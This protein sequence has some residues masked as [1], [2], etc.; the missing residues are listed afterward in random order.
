MSTDN[1]PAPQVEI[2]LPELPEPF[3]IVKDV[4]RFNYIHDVD[5]YTADQMRAYAQAAL[6]ARAGGDGWLPIE[7]AP[8]DGTYILA[9]VPGFVP[10]VAKWRAERGSFEYMDADNFSSDDQYE[11]FLMATDSW[12]PTHWQPLPTPPAALASQA[13]GVGDGN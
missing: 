9:I 2:Q 5:V 13:V 10:A 11:E 6:N 1:T 8:K 4:D 12:A 3:E 7:S